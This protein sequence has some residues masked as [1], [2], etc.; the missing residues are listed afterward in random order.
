MHDARSKW[1]VMIATQHKVETNG[2]EKE[3]PEAKP[4]FDHMAWQVQS[5]F[6]FNNFYDQM[7]S[8]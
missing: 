2:T 1:Q 8:T 3:V 4:N 5:L 6:K 7:D